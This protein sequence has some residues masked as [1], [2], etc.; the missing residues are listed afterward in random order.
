MMGLLLIAVQSVAPGMPDWI[1]GLIAFGAIV[2]PLLF[3]PLAWGPKVAQ[4]KLY[5]VI[6]IISFSTLSIGLPALAIWA[7]GS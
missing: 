6:A 4:N 1:R 5:R 3:A 7:I 2:N